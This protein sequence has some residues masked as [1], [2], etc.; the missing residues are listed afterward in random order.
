MVA[1]TI[2]YILPERILN[3][4]SALVILFQAVGG[5]IIAYIIFQIIK[6]SLSKKSKK[7][8]EEI[9]TIV[10]RLEKKVD[11]LKK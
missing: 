8:L 10:K 7:E 6:I 4:I 11:K 3:Q 2:S 9:K 1:E 5:M